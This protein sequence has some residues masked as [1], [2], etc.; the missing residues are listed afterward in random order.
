[1]AT[2]PPLFVA[3]NNW[4]GVLPFPGIEARPP[5]IQGVG[6]AGAGNAVGGFAHPDIKRLT[7]LL[8]NDGRFSLASQTVGMPIVEPYIPIVANVPL[9]VD[10]SG[11]PIDI[12]GLQL[13]FISSDINLVFVHALGEP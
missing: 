13:F 10:L 9:T 11:C 12:V 8:P 6:I 2:Q 4:N 1:M 7:I 5:F 3:T